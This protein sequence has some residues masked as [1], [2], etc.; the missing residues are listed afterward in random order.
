MTHAVEIRTLLVTLDPG[1]ADTITVISRELGIDVQRSSS[2]GEVPEELG[3]TKYEALLLDFDT[4]AETAP[5]LDL[6]RGSPSNKSALIFAVATGPSHRQEALQQGANFVLE[7][8]LAATEIRRSLY[9][10]YELM[11]RE[12]RRYFRYSAEFPVLLEQCSSGISFR[13]TSINI[14]STGAA[15]STPSALKPGERVNLSLL[16]PDPEL[17]VRASGT[18]V[19]DD[20]HGKAGI[21]FQ[22]SSPAL[23][24]EFSLWLDARFSELLPPPRAH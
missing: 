12:R 9:A 11:A 3:R 15:L 7:R 13:C 10:A 23:Q 14:S 24:K 18:V 17:A 21:N 1:L 6:V 22:C 5:I 19:W 8:P 16:L 4:V 20:Q 2:V